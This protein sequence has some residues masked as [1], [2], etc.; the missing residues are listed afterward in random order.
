MYHSLHNLSKFKLGKEISGYG[1]M[2]VRTQ[3]EIT[4]LVRETRS[5][6]GLTQIQLVQKYEFWSKR[7]P[8]EEWAEYV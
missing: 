3:V 4:D 8:L 7:Q 6:L 5:R 1:A 2:R